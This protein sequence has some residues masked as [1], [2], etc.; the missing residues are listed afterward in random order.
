VVIIGRSI[1][2]KAIEKHFASSVQPLLKE[3]DDLVV[4]FLEIAVFEL[5][6]EGQ[7]AKCRI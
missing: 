4:D 7:S 3:A 1:P 5:L 6:P 2:N